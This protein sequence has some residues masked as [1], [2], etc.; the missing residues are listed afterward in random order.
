MVALYA[1]DYERAPVAF[2]RRFIFEMNEGFVE[3]GIRV[4]QGHETMVLD[5]WL[6]ACACISHVLT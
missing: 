2:L 1:S 5:S 4:N 3:S 6:A